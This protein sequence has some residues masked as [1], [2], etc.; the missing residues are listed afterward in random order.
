MLN[1]IRTLAELT[2]PL[3]SISVC[4]DPADN[5]LLAMAE[6]GKAEYL[7]TGDERHLLMLEL[8]ASTHIVTAR[9][10]AQMLGFTALR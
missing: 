10:A 2:G 5:L 8:H 9:Q 3:P 7:V 6:A 1:E 4:A